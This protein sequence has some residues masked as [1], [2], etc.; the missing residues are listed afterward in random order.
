MPL[1]V[2]LSMVFGIFKQKQSIIDSG[3]TWRHTRGYKIE[4]VGEAS[5]QKNLSRICG[6]KSERGAKDEHICLLVPENKQH[7]P[8]IRVDIKGKPVAYITRDQVEEYYKALTAHG[9]EDQAVSARAKIVG[10]WKRTH[11]DEDLDD[12]VVTEGHFGVKLNMHWPPEFA[13]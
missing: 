1:S 8:A 11:Y 3:K 4:V 2:G 9:L 10:G 12:E 6:G 5:Y 13:K 7:G